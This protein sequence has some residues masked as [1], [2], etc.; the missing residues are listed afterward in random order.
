MRRDGRDRR[1]CDFFC[2][3]VPICELVR[4]PV[5]ALVV[6]VCCERG[7][8]FENSRS[9]RGWNG[10]RSPSQGHIASSTLY[11]GFLEPCTSSYGSLLDAREVQIVRSAQLLEHAVHHSC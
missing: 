10:Q 5:H 4:A 8:Y 7:F 11:P 1:L 6:S 3:G 2:F 9:M